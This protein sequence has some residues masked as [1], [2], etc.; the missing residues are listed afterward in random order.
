MALQLTLQGR[1]FDKGRPTGKYAQSVTEG[2]QKPMARAVTN[3]FRDAARGIQAEGRAAI[4]S[5]GLGPRFA[6]QFRVFAFPRRQFSLAPALRGWHARGWG[7]SRIGRYANIFAHGGTIH[8]K[9]GLLWIPLPTAPKLAG[10][11]HLT[12]AIYAAEIGPL[13]SLRGT[14]RPLLAGQSLRAVVG[15]R[16]SVAQLKTGARNAAARKAGG[17]GRRTVLVP[18]F[19]GLSSVH[20]EK[21]V[22]IEGVFRRW[23]ARIPEL[24]QARLASINQA[25]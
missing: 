14:R 3:A 12:P 5:G 10:G 6:R 15:R 13:V 17:K 18:I 1:A 11:R 25:S 2:F 19:V 21:R 16:A 9:G 8:G 24:Y 20:I 23:N 7:H 4:L 22:D